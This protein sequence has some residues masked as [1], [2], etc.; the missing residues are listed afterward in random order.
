MAGKRAASG[1]ERNHGC[2]ADTGFAP[3]ADTLKLAQFGEPI[4]TDNNRNGKACNGHGA[5]TQIRLF[6]EILQVH[7]VKCGKQGSGCESE[8]SD[9]EFEVQKHE[10]VAIGIQDGFNAVV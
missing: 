10:G 4:D 2:T 3:H 6:D 8:R 7:S 9:A 5:K 1:R